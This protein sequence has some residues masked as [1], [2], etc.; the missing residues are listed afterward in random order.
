MALDYASKLGVDLLALVIDDYV[1]WQGNVIRACLEKRALQV[2]SPPVFEQWLESANLSP[3][4]SDRVR[5][6]N[7]GMIDAAQA[8]NQKSISGE[9]SQVSLFNDFS[10]HY[11]EFIQQLHRLEIDTAVENSGYDKKTGLRTAKLMKDD[12]NRELERL[13]RRG[14]PFSIVLA[15]ISNFEEGWRKNPDIIK[16][17]IFHISDRIRESLRTFDEAYYLGDEYFL[18]CLKHADIV[19]GQSAMRRFNDVMK[20]RPVP[21]VGREDD[22]DVFITAVLH[23]PEPGDDVDKLIALM[24]TDLDNVQEKGVVLQYHD[25]SPLQR[26]IQST[27]KAK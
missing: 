5:K 4:L 19:G 3:E 25:M 12:I 22:D 17:M 9:T 13:S 6:M 23:E 24:K 21:I 18:L 1:A 7:A 26:Y 16:D 15:K 20:Q 8:Y 14:N 10:G 2:V 27:E 11:E